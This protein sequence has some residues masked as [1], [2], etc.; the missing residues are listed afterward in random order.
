VESEVQRLR[1][2]SLTA[3]RA[4]Q[5]ARLETATDR[6]ASGNDGLTAVLGD[7]DSVARK[8][9]SQILHMGAQAVVT[10][11]DAS[12]N[13]VSQAEG[14]LLEN[15]RQ[16]RSAVFDMRMQLFAA[17]ADQLVA[18]QLASM[19]SV[20]NKWFWLLG[21]VAI[22]TLVGIAIHD[23]RHE[24]R[25]RLNGGK[26]R[27]MGL[28]RLLLGLVAGL[29]L[30][31]TATFLC[32]DRIYE[33]LVEIGAG[34]GTPARVEIAEENRA[35]AEQS[36]AALKEAKAAELRYK[37]ALDHYRQG[38][39]KLE[40]YAPGLLEQS[41][42]VES[43]VDR[44]AA[45][46]RVQAGVSQRLAADLKEIE[47][48]RKE[49][50]AQ[51]AQIAK[52]GG[53]RLK[54]RGVLGLGLLG[55][56][57][58]GTW[59]F[60]RSVRRR[61]EQARKTCPICLGQ[62]AFEAVPDADATSTMMHG[63]VRCPN[64]ECGFSF[65]PIYQDLSKPCFPTLGIPRA[66]KTHWLAMTYRELSRGNYPESVQFENM[67]SNKS[68][69][70][71]LI[72]D[73]I[74]NKKIDP[75]ATQTERIPDPLVFNFRDHDRW[76]ISEVLLS[77]FDYSGEVTR[78]REHAQRARALDADGYLFFLDPTATSEEQS[79]TLADFR[80]DLRRIRKVKPGQQL[81]TPVALCVS[82]IDLMATES[83]A[84][85]S[86]TGIIDNF[87]AELAAIGWNLDM[88]SIEA[89]SELMSRLRDTIWPGWQI[90]RQINDLF[91][92]RYRFFPLTPVGLDGIGE[93]DLHHRTIAPVGLNEPLLWLLQMNGY[94]VLQ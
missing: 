39:E 49:C 90:E 88:R 6:G 40:D 51:A 80:E 54:I 55:L 93:R 33:W 62:A 1:S 21:L 53:R 92:G 10:Q 69:E 36:Q 78:D 45:S 83:Y 56:A 91:G 7:V 20:N 86:G 59:L 58:S 52:L 94:P 65:M 72:V 76:G 41:V 24:V 27:S 4:A 38:A 8:I 48:L 57:A 73:D 71:D 50:S 89:R 77:I 28:S 25:R 30:I 64:A 85:S 34:A 14:A 32:G 67:R 84:D 61:R 68:K 79:Q 44:L 5:L 12:A 18:G 3:A 43:L 47:V 82:K 42:R 87:Y 74:L 46:L 66:G 70:F 26:A 31:T 60:E 75:A 35:L 19:L 81:H 13:T 9:L 11:L 16:A 15:W 29:A 23:R 63:M 37:T 17:H 22:A 2:E